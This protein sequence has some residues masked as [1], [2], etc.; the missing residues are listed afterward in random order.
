MAPT[1]EPY[2]FGRRAMEIGSSYRFFFPYELLGTGPNGP[3]TTRSIAPNRIYANPIYTGSGG[4]ISQV[5]VPYD[6]NAGS[7][8]VALYAADGPQGVYP[9]TLVHEVGCGFG[10]I[11]VWSTDYTVSAGQ[12]LWTAF[13]VSAFAGADD[14]MAMRPHRSPLGYPEPPYFMRTTVTRSWAAGDWPANF[15]ST[16]A[17]VVQEYDYAL[18]VLPLAFDI[19]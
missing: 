9:G 6:F 15:A 3:T 17:D 13:N 11:V 7:V 10:S 1:F 18:G 14:A 8:H 5:W 12:W 19:T 2:R 16:L 4:R